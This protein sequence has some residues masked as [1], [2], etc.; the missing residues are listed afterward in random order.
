GIAL[1]GFTKCEAPA[2][3]P[4]LTIEEVL[5]DRLSDLNIP[6]VSDLPFG[7]DSPNAALPVGVMA[8]LDAK[9]GILEIKK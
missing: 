6:I 4:S 8:T 7:H 1:G 3:V 9:A 5:Q 2:N